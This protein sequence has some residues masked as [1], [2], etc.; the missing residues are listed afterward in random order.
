[1]RGWLHMATHLMVASIVAAA[2]CAAKQLSFPS[3]PAHWSEAANDPAPS[4]GDFSFESLSFVDGAHGWIVGDRYMLHVDGDRL[5][6][7]F[8]RSS[9]ICVSDIDATDAAQLLAAGFVPARPGGKTVGVVLRRD[10]SSW[11]V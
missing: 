9:D 3:V 11:R 7:Q 10:G 2:P 1:M 6:L 5:E 4:T 8:L